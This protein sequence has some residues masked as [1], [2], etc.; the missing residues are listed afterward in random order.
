MAL[1][2]RRSSDGTQVLRFGFP[3]GSLQDNTASLFERAGYRVSFPDRSLFPSIDD[4]EIECV[5]IR[6]Q[7]IARYVEA[8]ALDAGI[9]GHDWIVENRAKVEELADLEYSKQSFRPTRWVLAVSEDSEIRKVSDVEG[10]LIA[11]EGVG[12]VRAWLKKQGVKARVEFS[13]GAT[14]VKPPLLA[15]AIIDVT[16]TG[17]SIT[18]NG[19]RI[20]DVLLVS[21]PRFIANKQARA[22]AWK[23]AKMDRLLLLLNGAIAASTRVGLG[24]NVRREHLD[25]VLALLPALDTPTIS[26]LADES[27]VDVYAVVEEKRVRDLVPELSAAGARGIIESPLNKIIY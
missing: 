8:G 17:S 25:A 2:A 20:M 21:T 16:V 13:W 6:A 23:R 15:D 3:K 19:L 24:M 14:E 1:G 4:P 5:L 22:D 12:L 9:T 26:K 10:K 11:T 18:A 7:E 27:C